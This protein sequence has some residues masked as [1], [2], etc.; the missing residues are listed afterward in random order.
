MDVL[1]NDWKTTLHA[2]VAGTTSRVLVLSPF[3][4][5][6]ALEVFRSLRQRN[7]ACRL[8]TRLNKADFWHRSRAAT[9]TSPPSK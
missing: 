1:T 9:P 7:V 4:T 6:V 8:I 2:L 5:E 3:I